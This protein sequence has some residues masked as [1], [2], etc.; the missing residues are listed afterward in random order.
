MLLVL[1][2]VCVTFRSLTGR[3]DRCE[4]ALQPVRNCPD[5]GLALYRCR[6]TFSSR[7]CHAHSCTATTHVRLALF[8]Q[9][10]VTSTPSGFRVAD[11]R[12]TCR[13]VRHAVPLALSPLHGEAK[14]SR[15]FRGIRLI[16]VKAT[17]WRGSDSRSTG[18]LF[19]E[20]LFH[21]A[22]NDR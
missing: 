3:R 18:R 21:A 9:R 11:R 6:F 7:A 17:D 15:L 2:A 1:K 16:H 14:R 22:A 10:S 12:A 19:A 13:L 8:S 5:T 4:R 20:Y